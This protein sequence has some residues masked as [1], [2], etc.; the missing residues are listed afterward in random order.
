M[1]RQ[2]RKRYSP[3]TRLG[4][5]VAGWLFFGIAVF[6]GAAAGQSQAALVF[7]LFGGM[8]GALSVSAL[9]AWRM[10]GAVRV[11]REMPERAWQNQTLHFSYVLRNVRRRGSC[12]ALHINELAPEG[13]QSVSGFCVEVP[14]LASFRAGA[15]FAAR[16]RGRIQLEALRVHTGF[17]FGLVW[18]RRVISIPA[19]LV[20]W[21]AI[22]RL[23]RQLLYRGAVET[24]AAA[25]S[26]V[27]G[28]QDEFFG[29][30]EYRPGDNPRWI[31][32]RRSASRSTPVLREMAQPLPEILWVL[33]DTCLGDGTPAAYDRRES[34]LRFAATL[35]DHAMVRGF[36]VGMAVAYRDRIA[37]LPPD[38][39]RGQRRCLVPAQ[40]PSSPLGT[41]NPRRTRA[42]GGV[43]G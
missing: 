33:V 31:H 35:I 11:W 9:L 13:V 5:S 34:I 39:G 41:L 19:S 15:R 42:G 40:C 3:R 21:P 38:E 26:G 28:G 17:P 14:P 29:L 6:V 36:R 30:R 2:G 1:P 22:G 4:L 10:V 25:P 18:A 16:H 23:K 32:W 7:I 27:S 37:V 8:L 12:L 20:V 43:A 24:S